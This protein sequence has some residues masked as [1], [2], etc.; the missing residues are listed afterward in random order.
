M[1]THS[2][3]EAETLCKRMGIMVNGE[4]VCL[5]KSS[6]IKDRYGYGYEIDIR[7]KPMSSSQLNTF[8]EK[9][10]AKDNT[11]PYDTQTNEQ[12]NFNN[13]MYNKKTKI[14]N[15]NINDI[16]IRLNKNNFNN[17]LKE[18]RLGKKI[19]RDI[20]ING[21]ISLI[22]LINWI[23]FLENAFKFIQYAK[24]YFEEIILSEYLE[25]N[26]LFKMKKGENTKSIGFFFGLFEQHK[27]ECFITEYSIQPTSL[28][29]I[30]NK[31]AKEQIA[32][33]NVEK[34]KKNLDVE[35]NEINNDILVDEKLFNEI[36][37]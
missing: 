35:K 29:Q 21:S 7:I 9:L 14:N 17:E 24:D 2:M 8:I 12:Y 16:L 27:E 31:F 23:F 19:I 5:G 1:T 22:T 4:F 3:D 36:L 20:K 30:F 10:N 34:K 18:D 15:S 32:V 37:N 33:Q 11:F 13:N 25:N 28:E 26:F 6:Q